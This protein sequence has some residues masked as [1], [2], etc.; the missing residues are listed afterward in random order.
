ETELLEQLW[1]VCAQLPPRGDVA[2]RLA[3][4]EVRDE[5]DGLL[6][7]DVFLTVRHCDGVLVAIAVGADLMSVVVHHLAL[8]REGLE[9]MTGDEPACLEIAAFEH[10]QQPG[11]SDFAG[12]DAPLNVRGRVFPAVGT[13]PT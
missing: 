2:K 4:G 13:E 10:L 3:A 7:D 11:N 12:E 6:H 9:R 5:L 1:S 8:V